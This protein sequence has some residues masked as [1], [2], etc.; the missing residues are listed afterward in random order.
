[1]TTLIQ[2]SVKTSALTTRPELDLLLCC[3]RTRVD[4]ETAEHIKTLVQE[5][6]EWRYLVQTSLRH[7]VMSLLYQNLNA[8]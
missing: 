4:A 3:A 8:I 6:I 5:N 7:G 2:P 1:M